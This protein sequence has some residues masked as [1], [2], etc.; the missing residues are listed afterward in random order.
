MAGSMHKP[1]MEDPKKNCT[2]CHGNDLHG[3]TGQSCY[4]CHNADDHTHSYGGAKHK[5]GSASTCTVCH[6]PGNSGG[7]GP[8]CSS[9]H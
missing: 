7:L 8:A 2:A 5:G 6:G 1:G 4:N 3:G 9:C